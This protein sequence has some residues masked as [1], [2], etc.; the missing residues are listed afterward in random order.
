MVGCIVE[1]MVNNC[2]LYVYHVTKKNGK[3]TWKYLGK[4]AD[5]DMEEVRKN[6]GIVD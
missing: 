4:K 6:F 2:G 3:Q 5:L 1:K